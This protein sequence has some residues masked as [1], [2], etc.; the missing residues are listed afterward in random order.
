MTVQE[1]QQMP[2]R[3]FLDE[4]HKALFLPEYANNE[5][6]GFLIGELC[7]RLQFA[8]DNGVRRV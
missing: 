8:D 3:E 2:F 4:Y 7:R 6:K 1:I 5:T